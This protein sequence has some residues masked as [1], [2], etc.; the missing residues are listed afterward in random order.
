MPTGTCS[1][2]SRRWSTP[3]W[4]CN[5]TSSCR[6]PALV[7]RVYDIAAPLNM[8][9]VLH[10]SQRKE[11][12]MQVLQQCWSI[13]QCQYR[14]G[15]WQYDGVLAE[16]C[17]LL[18]DMGQSSKALVLIDCAIKVAEDKGDSAVISHLKELAACY[19]QRPKSEAPMLKR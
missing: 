15:Q 11:A 18:A 4:P 17:S 9:V 10:Y 13:S 14:P 5:G 12:A 2:W 8:A 19:E 7:D 16:H 6:N 3:V 1:N